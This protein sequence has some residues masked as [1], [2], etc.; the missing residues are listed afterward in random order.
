MSRRAFEVGIQ[1]AYY[2]LWVLFACGFAAALIGQLHDSSRDIGYVVGSI[3][4]GTL[5]FGVVIPWLLMRAVRW[6]YVGVVNATEN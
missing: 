2:V 1:R 6:I 5:F 4:V 3:V